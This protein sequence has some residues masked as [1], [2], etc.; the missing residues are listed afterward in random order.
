MIN[1]DMLCYA[2]DMYFKT[3]KMNLKRQINISA[4]FVVMGTL[5]SLFLRDF[6]V[7]MNNTLD[8]TMASSYAK[9]SKKVKTVNTGKNYKISMTQI[10]FTSDLFQCIYILVSDIHK[11]F[12]NNNK[13]LV[14]ILRLF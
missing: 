1:L 5:K 10:F 14:L 7:G 13:R 8:D 12:L 4:N 11:I 2:Y 6:V 9:C 3:N